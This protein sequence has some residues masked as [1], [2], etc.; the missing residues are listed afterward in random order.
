[1]QHRIDIPI[2]AQYAD[3]AFYLDMLRANF[4]DL[5]S[6]PLITCG[7]TTTEFIA[8]F[9]QDEHLLTW[10]QWCIAN[11]VNFEYTFKGD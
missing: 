7:G 6:S 11:G 1:M 8:Q 10:V 3:H 2:T 9:A 5:T 4:P